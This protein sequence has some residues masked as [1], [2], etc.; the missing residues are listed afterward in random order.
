MKEIILKIIDPLGLHARPASVIVATAGKYQSDIS[1]HKEDKK[2]NLKSIMGVMA[3]G[4]KQSDEIKI[5]AEG[6]DAEAAINDLVETFKSNNLI[7]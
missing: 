6:E 3:L 4:V 5:I 2:G 7:S 1:I